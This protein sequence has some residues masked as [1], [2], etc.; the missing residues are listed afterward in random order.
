MCG[1]EW[2]LRTW[3]Y[4]KEILKKYLGK[5]HLIHR[6]YL[7]FLIQLP[8]INQNK[9]VHFGFQLLDNHQNTV[10]SCATSLCH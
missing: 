7:R 6:F 1:F 9:V 4:F 10:N 2:S 8:I 5:S 3:K